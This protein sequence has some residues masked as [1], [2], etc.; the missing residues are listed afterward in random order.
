M[1]GTE[2]GFLQM[3]VRNRLTFVSVSESIFIVA[4]HKTLILILHERSLRLNI[5]AP[6]VMYFEYYYAALTVETS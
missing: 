1:E 2:A 6:R 3:D 5:Q 4:F